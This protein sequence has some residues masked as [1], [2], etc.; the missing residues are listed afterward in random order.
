MGYRRKDYDDDALVRAIADGL[1]TY[2]QIGKEL[3]LSGTM[4]WA[5]AHGQKLRDEMVLIV[6]H[7]DG[8]EETKVTVELP[9]AKESGVY[10]LKTGEKMATLGQA[11]P[12]F[13]VT[14]TEE[15]AVVVHVK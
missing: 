6:S 3:G 11:T 12:K 5:V 9:V 1:K 4:V 7:Y 8:A 13:E 10:D 15:R 2:R 14:F